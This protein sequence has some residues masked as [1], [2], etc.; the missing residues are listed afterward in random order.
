MRRLLMIP[1]MRW[2]SRLRHPTLFKWTAVAFAVS[3]LWPFDPIPLIDEIVLGLGTLWFA[4][5]KKENTV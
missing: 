1:L 3:V 5:W 4:A 2:A